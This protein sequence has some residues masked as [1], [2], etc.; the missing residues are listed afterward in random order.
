ML[1][2]ISNITMTKLGI[3]SLRVYPIIPMNIWST[4][5]L[6]DAPFLLED[7]Q[8]RDIISILTPDLNGFHQSTP[9]TPVRSFAST[10]FNCQMKM[11]TQ[12]S[13]RQKQRRDDLEIQ[14]RIKMTEAHIA[15]I[16]QTRFAHSVI[17]VTSQPW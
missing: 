4:I 3:I 16:Y 6:R 14:L 11:T 2:D 15:S 7:E 17:I 9:F 5:Q 1:V 10:N 12:L 8:I 13:S